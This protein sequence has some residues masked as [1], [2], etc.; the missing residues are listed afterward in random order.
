MKKRIG[1]VDTKAI[2]LLESLGCSWRKCSFC[3]YQKEKEPNYLSCVN[4]NDT[5]LDELV[6]T[7]GKYYKSKNPSI[8]SLQIIDSASYSELPLSTFLRLPQICADNN[9]SRAILEGHWMYRR[10]NYRVAKIFSK[11]NISTSFILGLES[12][13]FETRELVLKKGM[14]QL[15]QEEIKQYGY[16]YVNILFGFEGDSLSRL[17]TDLYTAKC[18]GLKVFLNIYENNST[19][20][21]RDN[22]LVEKFYKSPLCKVI[23]NPNSGVVLLDGAKG[24][25]LDGVGYEMKKEK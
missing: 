13:N 17:A 4:M 6:E 11:F 18:N 7:L 12:F 8:T 14:P 1:V 20:I 10:D 21:L 9:I 19:K 22:L 15:K 25:T 24:L 5:I 16:D 3:D 23:S 2:V